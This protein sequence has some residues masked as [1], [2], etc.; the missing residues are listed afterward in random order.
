MPAIKDVVNSPEFKALSPEAKKIVFDKVSA[1]DPEFQALSPEAR[2]TVMSRITGASAPSPAPQEATPQEPEKSGLQKLREGAA[3]LVNTAAGYLG[4]DLG[5][6]A[7]IR[8]NPKDKAL[9]EGYRQEQRQW[10]KDQ[11]NAAAEVGKGIVQAPFNIVGTGVAAIDNQLSQLFTGEDK[12]SSW[13]RGR[14][15][16]SDIAEGTVGQIQKYLLGPKSETPKAGIISSPLATLGNLI[17]GAISGTSEFTGIEKPAIETTLDAVGLGALGKAKAGLKTA[18]KTEA[19]A[20]LLDKGASGLATAKDAAG[21]LASI[22]PLAQTAR[23]VYGS[24]NTMLKEGRLQGALQDLQGMV[25][26]KTSAAEGGNAA[27][28]FGQAL[29]DIVQGKYDAAAQASVASQRAAKAAEL[30]QAR[31]VAQTAKQG[32]SDA[33]RAVNEAPTKPAASV[34]DNFEVGSDIASEV[35]KAID[36]AKTARRQEYQS[37]A[38]KAMEGFDQRVAEKMPAVVPKTPTASDLAL[39]SIA[40][41]VAKSLGEKPVVAVETAPKAPTPD[42]RQT[43]EAQAFKKQWEDKIASGEVS[44]AQGRAIASK[45][46]EV[47]GGETPLAAE[48]LRAVERELG[49]AG[50][51]GQDLTG[52]SAM[53]AELAKKIKSSFSEALDPYTGMRDVK[54]KYSDVTKDIESMSEGASGKVESLPAEKVGSTFFG[55][56]TGAQQLVETVGKE[57]ATSFAARHLD[58][59]LAGKDPLKAAD[60]LQKQ[61][62]LKEFPEVKRA[63]QN[64]LEASALDDFKAAQA[65]AWSKSAGKQYEQ[66]M[67]KLQAAREAAK[68]PVSPKVSADMQKALDNISSGGYTVD[69]PK[70]L[71]QLLNKSSEAQIRAMADHIKSSPEAMKALP[72][73]LKQHF[74]DPTP[75]RNGANSA[76]SDAYRYMASFE[77]AGVLSPEAVA[78]IQAKLQKVFEAS[79]GVKVRNSAPGKMRKAFATAMSDGFAKGILISQGLS[80]NGSPAD[81]EGTDF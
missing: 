37:A 40:D 59:V 18:A 56:R 5:K 7:A 12:G 44:P 79:P 63:A 39:S 68:K 55:G 74:A 72:D 69:A 61:E 29:K 21:K 35:T 41:E 80:K 10:S 77:K 42:W 36:D 76:L 1:Q 47:F 48:G 22:L 14:K 58:N 8:A 64:K 15:L 78:G 6:E 4:R 20:A 16:G 17:G 24:L 13:E 73:A 34:T 31:G 38:A 71:S 52:K 46:D 26:G 19:G 32:L 49:D 51:Y 62:W 57:K 75:W 33:S 50:K 2:S 3:D 11:A 23:S 25:E 54:A 67:T 27:A 65:D 9:A 30:R 28:S 81:S 53:N 66:A 45:L 70:V 43:P 60:W